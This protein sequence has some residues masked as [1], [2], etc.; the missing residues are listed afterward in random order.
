MSIQNMGSGPFAYTQ[1]QKKTQRKIDQRTLKRI[2]FA[3]RPYKGQ[4]VLVLLTILITTALGLVFPLMIPLVFDDALA[5]HNI[6]HLIIYAFIM[7]GATLISGVLGVA[8][9][10]LN[11]K[12]GQHVM[13]DFRNSLYAHLQN[14]S[15]RFFTSTRTGEIQSRLANDVSSAQ[16]VVTDT[17]SSVIT[18]FI[19]VL[20]TIIAMLY[21]SPLLT[22]VSF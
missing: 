15:L 18:S 13:R 6:N 14:M 10:Y 5:H 2:A 8:Q 9:A 19:N 1:E 17:F 11:N 12:V 22:V 3:F 21:L 4:V 16:G 7:V 20:A